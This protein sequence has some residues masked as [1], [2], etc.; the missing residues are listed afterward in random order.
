MSTVRV[1]GA[2]PQAKA[3]NFADLRALHTADAHAIL[4]HLEFAHLWGNLRSDV[5]GGG[6]N[7]TVRIDRQNPTPNASNIQIQTNGTSITIATVLV[8]DTMANQDANAV[9][10]AVRQ[11][12][13]GSLADGMQWEV[14]DEPVVAKQPVYAKGGK[15]GG[16]GKKGGGGRKK[17]GGPGKKG[18]SAGAKRG[19][20]VKV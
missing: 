11:A 12:F 6:N 7:Y 10:T 2:S 3:A 18:G 16:G 20:V 15:G 19:P 1:S 4:D 14:Y 13:R 8:R 17:G 9:L 5:T